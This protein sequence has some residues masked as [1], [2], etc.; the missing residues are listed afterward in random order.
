MKVGIRLIRGLSMAGL[1]FAGIII[2]L[3]PVIVPVGVAYPR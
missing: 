1:V 3:V 2:G